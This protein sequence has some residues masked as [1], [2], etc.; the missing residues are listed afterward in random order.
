MVILYRTLFAFLAALIAK[1]A[2]TLATFA[3]VV[4]QQKFLK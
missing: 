3:Q 2:N 1:L 4:I